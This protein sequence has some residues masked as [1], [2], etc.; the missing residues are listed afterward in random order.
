MVLKYNKTFVIPIP[1]LEIARYK[2]AKQSY[3]PK[4]LKIIIKN[5][6]CTIINKKDNKDEKS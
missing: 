3:I 6:K 4:G 5:G 2:A 1:N